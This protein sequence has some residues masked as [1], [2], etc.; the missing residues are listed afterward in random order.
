MLSIENIDNIIKEI[1]FVAL[2]YNSHKNQESLKKLA[3]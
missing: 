3:N 2:C 1:I